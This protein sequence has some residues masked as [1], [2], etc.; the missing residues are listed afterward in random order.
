MRRV[1]VV[2][3]PGTT[4]LDVVGPT[5]VFH[6][7]NE[8]GAGGARPYD[9]VVASAAGGP[10][11]ASSGL[12][13]DTEAIATVEGPVDTLMA[14]GGTGV[15]AAAADPAL[16]AHV[17]R[18]AEPARRVTSVC[19]GTFL[20]AAAGLLEGRRVTT[21]WGRAAALARDYPG[22]DIDPDRLFIRDGAVWTSAGVTAGIDLA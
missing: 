16:L 7:A 14:V 22:L 4:L 2:T 18:L 3:F 12:V 19:T 9:I 21:H 5:E 1:V 6:S 15:R 13:L 11:R 8:L 20:L 10:V 17:T